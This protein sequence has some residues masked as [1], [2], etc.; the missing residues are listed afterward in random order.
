MSTQSDFHSTLD[1][2][3][4]ALSNVTEGET[5]ETVWNSA[6]IN[7]TFSFIVPRKAVQ[8]VSVYQRYFYVR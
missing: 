7:G 8:A 1:T 6:I 3:A 4:T 2:M 5:P